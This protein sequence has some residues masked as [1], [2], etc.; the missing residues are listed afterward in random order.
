[1]DELVGRTGL[2]RL[3]CKS[4]VKYLQASIYPMSF[5]AVQYDVKIFTFRYLKQRVLTYFRNGAG[6]WNVVHL[7][8]Q[9]QYIPIGECG[10]VV[11]PFIFYNEIK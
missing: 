6:I 10:C 7:G 4:K 9:L 3:G 5:C 8:N 2:K 1:M 11:V